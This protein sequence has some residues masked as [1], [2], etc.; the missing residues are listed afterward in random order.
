MFFMRFKEN[1]DQF[2]IKCLVVI[3]S[4]E[5][6]AD[7]ELFSEVIKN[8]GSSVVG[9]SQENKIDYL[10]LLLYFYRIIFLVSFATLLIRTGIS[11]EINWRGK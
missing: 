1:C 2:S 11:L 6:Q 3:I 8:T 5:N 4:D 9:F 7:K 10:D